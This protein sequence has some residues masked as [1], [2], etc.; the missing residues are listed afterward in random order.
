MNPEKPLGIVSRSPII[1]VHRFPFTVHQ[2]QW[3]LFAHL[4]IVSFF[5]AS[6]QARASL[7]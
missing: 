3:Y 7:W 4:M 5:F 2:Y 1:A 6:R